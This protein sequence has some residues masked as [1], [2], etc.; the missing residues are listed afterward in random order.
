LLLVAV[1]AAAPL[2]V[3]AQGVSW[4]PIERSEFCVT[5]GS[6]E[7]SGGRMVIDSPQARATARTATPQFAEL[8]FTY[9]GPSAVTVP[10]GSGLERRQ[11]GLKL[12]AQDSCNVTYAMWHIAPDQRM[13]VA[14]KRNAGRHTHAECGNRGY[15]IA[16]MSTGALALTVGSA[17][18]LRATLR[19]DV[20]EIY[21][22]TVLALTTKLDPRMLDFDGPVGIR[23][24]NGR[25]R[26]QYFVG[27][28]ELGPVSRPLDRNTNKCH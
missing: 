25:F 19:A 24:D 27:G 23:T 26:F 17:H 3:R 9:L 1:S 18:T 12:R 14:I 10:L 13:E 21:A 20:V 22:D 8:H 4:R 15:R 5:D 16:A 7:R 11:I 6:I 2:P 28:P